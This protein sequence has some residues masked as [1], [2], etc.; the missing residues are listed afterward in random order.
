MEN[1]PLCRTIHST[2]TPSVLELLEVRTSYVNL[3][4]RVIIYNPLSLMV[5]APQLGLRPS[6]SLGTFR[7]LAVQ[8]RRIPFALVPWC[9]TC[10]KEGKDLM[11]QGVFSHYL[12]F[13]YRAT[14]I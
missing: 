2:I 11:E 5:R 6:Q 4:S 10:I 1:V 8:S 12:D 14:R 7:A 13:G 9:I 3:P